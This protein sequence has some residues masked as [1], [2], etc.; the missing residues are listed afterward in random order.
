MAN[1]AKHSK[2][3]E[4]G[5]GEARVRQGVNADSIWCGNGLR[6]PKAAPI[7]AGVLSHHRRRLMLFKQASARARSFGSADGFSVTGG[8]SSII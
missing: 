1:S 2:Q 3:S 7:K 8:R 4:E 5:D 6:P